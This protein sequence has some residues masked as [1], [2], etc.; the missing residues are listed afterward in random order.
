[1]ENMTLD[2]AKGIAEFAES[3]VK[4]EYGDNPF[5]VAVVDKDGFTVLY[6]KEDGAKLLTIALTP[7]KAYTAVRMGQPTADFLARL[8]REHLEI[9]YFADEKF[10]AMP[11]GVPIKNPASKMIGAVGIGGLKEDGEVAMKVAA[12]AESLMNQ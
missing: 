5:S 12:H 10:V 2:F 4:N 9:C 11:G 1:M 3:L 7:A 6:Q 8:Q